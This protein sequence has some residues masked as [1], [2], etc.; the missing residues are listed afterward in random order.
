MYPTPYV[1]RNR[2]VTE[3]GVDFID[4]IMFAFLVVIYTIKD[5]VLM[6]NLLL[7]INATFVKTI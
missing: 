5:R 6:L 4:C 1:L 2:D 7:V 3:I